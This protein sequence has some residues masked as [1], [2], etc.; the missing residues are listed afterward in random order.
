MPHAHVLQGLAANQHRG[1]CTLNTAQLSCNPVSCHT[2]RTKAALFATMRR[3]ARL[4]YRTA[5]G[6]CPALVSSG[7]G[8]CMHAV[9]RH[10][11]GR[12]T[13][14]KTACLRTGKCF[15]APLLSWTLLRD[16]NG[17]LPRKRG[18]AGL[19]FTCG[20]Q[21]DG[22]SLHMYCPSIGLPGSVPGCLGCSHPDCDN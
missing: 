9:A 19:G 21:F 7:V 14:S 15:R 11:H 13:Q 8:Q 1:S 18:T 17:L 20:F 6:G 10:L 5:P 4:L 2:K 16:R 3:L 12:K 22:T